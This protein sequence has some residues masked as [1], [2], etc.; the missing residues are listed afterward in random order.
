MTEKSLL[1]KC[2]FAG[3][4][5]MVGTDFPAARIFDTTTSSLAAVVELPLRR[6]TVSLAALTLT[7]VAIRQA[8]ENEAL[9]SSGKGSSLAGHRS[10]ALL[11]NKVA[12]Y[13]AAVGLSDGTV[14]LH[15][16][17]R[18]VQ[19]AHVQVSETQQP[20]ISLQ[21]CGG[22]AFCL[23][24]NHILY[25]VHV[26][27]AT[28]GPCLRLRVQPDASS[29]A[30]TTLTVMDTVA[31]T[32]ARTASRATDPH[33]IF[34]V[35][36]SGPT[37]ALY[38]VRALANNPSSNG[39]G[40]AMAGTAAA[41]TAVPPQVHATK[42]LAFPSQGTS[43]EFAWVS[44]VAPSALPAGGGGVSDTPVSLPAI[45]ASAQDGVVRIWDVRYTPPPSSAAASLLT[46]GLDS[47]AAP[48]SAVVARCRRTL[49]C[50]QR[51][52]NVSV[53]PD[54]TNGSRKGNYV[55][56]TTLTGSVLLWSLGDALLP[57]VVEPVPLKPD[58][59]LVS[60][61]A[62]GRLL[63]GAL[64]P[65]SG[66]P[67]HVAASDSPLRSLEMT[68][69]R[70]RFALPMFETKNIGDAVKEASS[71]AA[72]A[73]PESVATTGAAVEART[74]A[75]A[76][77]ANAANAQRT[78]LATLALGVAGT[79]AS[80]ATVVELPLNATHASLL[81]GQRDAEYLLQHTTDAATS[82]FVVM[83]TVWAAHQQQVAAKA[84]QYMTD[85]FK[86][87]QLYHAKSIQ[88]LPVKQYTLEQR[89]QQVAREEAA[90]A[91][92]RRQLSTGSAAAAEGASDGD[93][94]LEQRE[95]SDIKVGRSVLSHHALGLATVPLYQAL[96]ANDTSAVMDLLSMSARSAEGM[97]ATVLSLQLPYCLQLLHVISERLGLCSKAVEKVTPASQFGAGGGAESTI[98]YATAEQ[99]GHAAS[100]VSGSATADAAAQSADT[101]GSSGSGAA[102]RGGVAA[103]SI[104]SSLL[105]WI[106]AIVHYRGSELLAVQ[107][108]WDAQE[109]AGRASET[110]PPMVASPPKDFLAPIL[111]H[112]ESL[113]SQYDKLAV[114]YG[115]L[116][117]F[118][119]VRPS[120]KNEFMNIPRKSLSS[121]MEMGRPV[122]AVS[123]G[124]AT[125]SGSSKRRLHLT[126]RGSVVDDD[127]LFPVMFKESRSRSG[128]RVVRVRSKLEIE[129]KRRQRESKGVVLQKRAR[130]LAREQL[131]S[132]KAAHSILDD[133]SDM[134]RG[135]GRGDLDVMDQ[136]MMAEMAGKDGEMD[137]DAL[138][139][140]DLADDVSVTNMPSD[141][142]F[143]SE[144]DEE[145]EDGSEEE[146]ESATAARGKCKKTRRE[147]VVA[148]EMLADA[149]DEESDDGQDKDDD[150]AL[151]SSEAEFSSG[152]D[153]DVDSHSLD[154]DDEESDA[155]D[156]EDEGEEQES[157]DDDKTQTS[158]ELSD[159]DEDDGMGED[160]QELLSRHE[161]DTDRSERRKAKKVRTD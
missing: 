67:S 50:G 6:R 74:K 88:D 15:D 33:R 72:A 120:Q 122:L 10:E 93:D 133:S 89:L 112:Y 85:A 107:R 56:V 131:Q 40:G 150:A 21:I 155:E 127:I 36:V 35:L 161:D 18:D 92:R 102:L 1:L 96:H 9:A 12:T 90:A 95:G 38:E 115:R 75:R 146:A 123:G 143:D 32:E 69:L 3:H 149:G 116:S 97:R 134:K 78:A 19:V 144:A 27:N 73:P 99:G 54:T 63:F 148:D 153:D 81:A 158:D 64:R 86:A 138:E 17:R 28:S 124:L 71:A 109:A 70:G 83:D 135:G 151:D 44:S 4:Y 2:D 129:K 37:N 111:H 105:E 119:S 41:N 48:S 55:M 65:A 76:A 79:N 110:T 47:V 113:C 52:L 117:I 87:P 130:A 39:S 57:P 154:G 58:V 152:S 108:D 11:D 114:L 24:A 100:T 53:L 132:T 8:E 59:V 103:F 13:Y 101:N 5:F 46:T 142:S 160:M 7:S 126:G 45:T 128:P 22:Y 118:K 125:S 25:V 51:I 147:A 43:A 77:K 61:V 23:A 34:R 136:I 140:M 98:A 121:N 106:D 145:G 14:I 82:A 159:E 62:A 156:D 91:L 66:G 60:A 137:L 68:L 104:R 49:L 29:I 30:V 26:Q 139:A 141:G 16:V 42:L 80:V 20:I 94:A 157:G 31:V 84:S